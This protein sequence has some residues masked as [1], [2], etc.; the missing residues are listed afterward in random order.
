MKIIL[1]AMSGDNAPLEVLRGAILAKESI[2]AIEISLVGDPDLLSECAA[3]N[4]LSLDG[5]EIVSAPT[6]ITMEDP[7]LCVVHEKKDS[8]M[9][10]GLKMLSLGE[11]DAFVSA[12]NTGA[13]LAGASLIVRRLKGVAR[14][15]IGAILPLSNPVLLL[16]SGANITVT[17]E[18][19]EMFALMG[20]VY[21]RKIYGIESP[22]VG[23]ANN[24][25]EPT[26]GLPLQIAAYD[27]LSSNTEINFVGNIEGKD[28]PFNACDV[29]V[30]D[31]FTG[32]VILKMAEGMGRLML[33][34][35]KELFASNLFA[36]ISAGMMT[37]KIN[38]LK[39]RF[40]SSEHGGAP[41]LGVRRPVIKAH[42]GSDAKAIKNAII[43]AE[44]FVRDDVNGEIER[45]AA[46]LAESKNS[47]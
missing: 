8:S 25:T 35:M 3:E 16:D 6:V 21:M 42:G 34:T 40:D 37:A 44:K 2:P 1:D 31:G 7:P 4:K 32:N 47:K 20:S 10:T 12:G 14:P 15:G 22:R 11:G 28:I 13:L 24:G 45:V 27:R 29:L 9:G 36:M 39:H 23:Q 26:K 46:A 43:Q 5:F 19:L 17:D 18:N 41:I 33:N 30:T 38:D